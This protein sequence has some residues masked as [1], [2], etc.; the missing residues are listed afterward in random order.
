MESMDH[1]IDTWPNRIKDKDLKWL[2]LDTFTVKLIG[3]YIDIYQQVGCDFT[4]FELVF[5]LPIVAAFKTYSGV[6]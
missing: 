4:Q 6:I 5:S 2:H 3:K 1:C